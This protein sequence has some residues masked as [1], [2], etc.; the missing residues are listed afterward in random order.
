MLVVGGFGQGGLLIV[1]GNGPGCTIDDKAAELGLGG[2]EDLHIRR[3]SVELLVGVGWPFLHVDV[4]ALL[5]WAT[6]GVCTCILWNT[7]IF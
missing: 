2:G 1:G 6:A 5:A 7:Q 4:L 3:G